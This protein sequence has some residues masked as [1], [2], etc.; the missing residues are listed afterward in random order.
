MKTILITA[1]TLLA[2]IGVSYSAQAATMFKAKLS[3]DKIVDTNGN[4]APT[5]SLGKGSAVL[6]LNNTETELAYSITLNN[7]ALDI[8]GGTVTKI[9]F[10]TGFDHQRSPFHVLN[11]HGP[12]DDADAVF[13]STTAAIT[14]S[15]IW[16]NSDYCFTA[17]KAGF[18]CD[19][20]PDTTKKLSDYVS[21]L[22]QG[23]LYINIHTSAVPSGEIRGQ[24][25]P[26]PEP[27]TILG[28]GAALGFGTFFK[29]KRKNFKK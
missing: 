12:K 7:L 25:Q 13:S 2:S 1:V 20:D 23:G 19:T 24:I 16:S 15:G 27:F 14:L 17:P 28:A 5:G 18:T 26:I 22:K 10:H 29:S 21:L 8:D 4:P 3:G 9:H 11:I 6:W